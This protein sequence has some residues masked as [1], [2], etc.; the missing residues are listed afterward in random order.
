MNRGI[1]VILNPAA[2]R[3]RGM[4]QW[5]RLEAM[6]KRD[7]QP[8][9]VS[10]TRQ[11][12]EL[13]P[14]V[15][16]AARAD[17]DCLLIIGGDGSM[18]HALNGW[19]QSTTPLEKRPLLTLLPAG[20]GND[21]ATYWGISRDVEQW[22]AAFPAWSQQ[23]H[24]A[25]LIERHD[26]TEKRYFLN[27]AGMAYD[28]WLV[29]AIE[30]APG[31]KGSPFVYPLSVLKGLW[32]YSPQ[33]AQV[34][35]DDE[36]FDGRFYTI[37][38]GICP[39]SGG[40]MRLVPHARH[41]LDGLAVTVAGALPMMRILANLWRFYHGSIGQVRGVETRICRQLSVN[42][43]DEAPWHLEAD[44]EYLGTGPCRIR[45]VERAFRVWAPGKDHDVR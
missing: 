9:T 1:Q 19:M 15:R 7:G 36:A 29:H 25:G 3:G 43:L 28:G 14:M 26:T 27:V 6:F 41:D 4:R 12:D 34:F 23:L 38:A 17:S 5:R 39:Y 42:P 45:L 24:N 21:W 22:W 20:S 40:G 11:A 44:G 30:A 18:H 32:R 8:H 33:R 16:H 13:T 31:A 10:V 35:I 2:G 37:N